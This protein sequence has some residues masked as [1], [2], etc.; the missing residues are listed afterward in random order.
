MA[1]DNAKPARPDDGKARELAPVVIPSP[2]APYK[3]MDGVGQFWANWKPESRLDKARLFRAFQQADLSA[4]DV[5]GKTICV[6]HILVHP[7]DIVREDTG[8]VIPCHR[9]V[10]I[11]DD[12]RTVGFVSNGILKALSLVCMLEGQGPW[13]PGLGMVVKQLSLKNGRRTYTID[14]PE[15]EDCEPVPGNKR[16]PR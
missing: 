1:H 9:C 15:G 8:E 6:S 16:R 13:K 7:I 14:L 2:I 3:P 10:L 11:L 5:I 12:D 4:D